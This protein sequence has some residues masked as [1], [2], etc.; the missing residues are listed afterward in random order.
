MN[1]NERAK[2]IVYLRIV[3]MYF[4]SLLAQLQD[5]LLKLGF[6]W[7]LGT[8]SETLDTR[9]SVRII[10]VSCS[11]ERNLFPEAASRSIQ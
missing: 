2:A 3:Y 1:F 10:T 7:N 8:L 11:R 9:R 4:G 6:D 5:V